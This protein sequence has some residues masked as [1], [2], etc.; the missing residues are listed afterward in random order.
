MVPPVGVEPTSLGLEHLLNPFQ[1]F[2]EDLESFEISTVA[3]RGRYSASE[4]QVLVRVR[5]AARR[6]SRSQTARSTAELYS[7]FP[8]G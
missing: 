7:D 6:T 1:G 5:R 8:D 3:L 2:M 4:L